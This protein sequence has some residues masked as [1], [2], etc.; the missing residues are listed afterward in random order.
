MN[1][2]MSVSKIF[3]SG[4]LIG[5]LTGIGIMYL[6]NGLLGHAEMKEAILAFLVFEGIAVVGL[7]KVF[8]QLKYIWGISL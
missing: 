6:I 7:I 1:K 8:K 3:I 5:L 4:V 2:H